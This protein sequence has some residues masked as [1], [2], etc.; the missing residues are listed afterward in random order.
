VNFW[1][2]LLGVN[3]LIFLP[4]YF[5]NL[6]NEPNPFDF[7][8][9]RTKSAKD[10]IRNT[11][12][13]DSSDPFRVLLEYSVAMLVIK[14]MGYN[15]LWTV[16]FL[17][18]IAL[19]G[20]LTHIYVAVMVYVF[21]RPPVI[22]SDL[23]FLKVGL[24]I[25]YK[26]RV[27]IFIGFGLL[28][29]LLFYLFFHTSTFLLSLDA[30]LWQMI[31]ALIVFICLGLF[32][33][34]GYGYASFHHRV[35]YSFIIHMI[36]NYLNGNQYKSLLEKDKTFFEQFNIY[37][38]LELDQKPNVVIFSIESYGS[39]VFKDEELKKSIDPILEKYK[40]QLSNKGFLIQSSL[41]NPPQFGGGSWLSYT[42]FLFG[43]KVDDMNQYNMLFKSNSAFRYYQSLLT[44]LKSKGYKNYLLCP[45]GGGYNDKVDWDI[46]KMNFDAD[47]FLNWERINYQG[48]KYQYLKMGYGPA[49]QYSIYKADEIIEQASAEPYSL[50]FSTLNSHIP[51]DSPEKMVEDW[52]VLNTPNDIEAEGE[53][54]NSDLFS[55]YKKAI[56]YQLSFILDYIVQKDEENTIYILFGDH[57]PP[58]ITKKEMG[59]STPIHIISRNKE[60]LEVFENVS[61][62]AGFYPERMDDS[63]FKHEGFYSLFM[64]AFN[65]AFG[66]EKNKELPFMSNGIQLK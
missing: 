38:D 12:A 32:H 35:F 57:Q 43:M 5:L 52:R 64:K 42:S 10:F 56:N 65:Y 7:I 30:A 21:N 48:K 2:S 62:S 33:V 8:F 17:A 41:S 50:F 45:L 11:Y 14:M 37:T 51:F 54:L 24:T 23:E 20:F 15:G 36:R 53:H 25:A 46:V 16:A 27:L 47:E 44:F 61:F 1:L 49:D 59:I 58:F 66:K 26:I 4:G 31:L 34:R 6:R 29:G 55:R 22:Q 13:R 9:N 19:S 40:E 63:S 28:V 3:I 60:F 18:I 39:I